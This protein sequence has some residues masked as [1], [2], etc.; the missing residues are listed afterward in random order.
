MRE[1]K[2]T[3]L[4]NLGVQMRSKDM[5][6]PMPFEDFL[7]LAAQ[8]PD[9]IFR[10]IFQLFYDMV[11]YY[12]SEGNPENPQEMTRYNFNNLFVKECDNP[13]FTDLLFANRFLKLTNGF[14]KGVQN[15]HIF[16]F[17]GPPGSGKSTFLNNLLQKFENYTQLPE[18]TTYQTYWRLDVK[19][20][21]GISRV[22]RVLAE[23]AEQNGNTELNSYSLFNQDYLQFACPSHDHPILHIPKSYRIQ[24]LDELIPD[25]SFKLKLFSEREYEW[26]FR[27]TPCTI[28]SSL[29]AS[30]LNILGDPMAVFEMLY[31]RKALFHRQYGEGISVFNPG[32]PLVERPIKSNVIQNMLNELLKT[33]EVNYVYS[34]LAKTNNGIFA[35]MDIKDHNVKRLM[36]LHGIISDGVHKVELIEERIKSLFVGLV[37]PADKSHYENVPSFRD[38]IITVSVPYILDYN[39][40]VSIYRNKFGKNLEAYFL[41]GVLENVGKII[42]SSRLNKESPA[43]HKWIAEPERYHKY[44]DKHSLLLKMEVYTGKIP[45]WLSEEDLKRFDKKIRKAVL[46]ESEQEGNK[47]FSGRQSLNIFNELLAKYVK[48]EKLITMDMVGQFFMK[49]EALKD[50]LP[51]GFI[52]SLVDMYDFNVLQEMKESI[53]SYNQS[54]I[55]KDIQ[56]YLYA[57]NFEEGDKVT[58]HY[59]GDTFVIDED[60]FYNFEALILGPGVDYDEHDEFRESTHGEYVSTTLAQEIHLEG[61]T[62]TDT[63]LYLSLFD[64]Y[65]RNLKENTLVPYLHNDNFR[66]A[67][68]DFGTNSF[69][70]YDKRI[71][72]DVSS[73]INNLQKKFRYTEEGAKQVCIYAL[74]KKLPEKY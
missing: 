12:I 69:N 27:E 39:T 56:N 17:E 20:L 40:E 58:C 30:L 31:V 23:V 8:E 34:G 24:F 21:G 16:L 9:R 53:Y 15:N 54:H 70:A 32:D 74:D 33:D 37:N 22:E 10:D 36:H 55:S 44:L 29:Y 7:K 62:I 18:G 73:L 48:T 63:Q 51:E 49:Q 45:A 26:V 52:E 6:I 42:V 72:Q 5:R 50:Q 4:A 57:I 28:C 64:K 3:A 65:K 43:I 46:A 67:V 13:F 1:P 66:R 41:P 14:K 35:L 61:K 19:K 59:T 47:G 38:R 71:K 25:D 60:Y 11:Y 2:I 68:L